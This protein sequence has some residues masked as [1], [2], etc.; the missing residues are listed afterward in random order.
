[1]KCLATFDLDHRQHRTEDYSY[2]ATDCPRYFAAIREETCI[3]SPDAV[4]DPR[5]NEFAESYLQPLGIASTLDVPF[6][7]QGKLA[8][9]FALECTG[10]R[11][12][13]ED[14]EIDFALSASNLVAVVLKP[15]A[16]AAPSRKRR[17]SASVPSNS[18]SISCLAPSRAA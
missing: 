7:A 16:S 15:R 8:G 1:L 6:W 12:V 14:D 2:C 10:A 4:S 3:V 5:M 17:T 9:V 18:C 11:H 13:W